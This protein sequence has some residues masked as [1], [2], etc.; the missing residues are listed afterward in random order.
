[1]RW[2]EWTVSSFSIPGDG[3][4]DSVSDLVSDG[5]NHALDFIAEVVHI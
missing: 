2:M 1:M 4:S 3:D 5:I